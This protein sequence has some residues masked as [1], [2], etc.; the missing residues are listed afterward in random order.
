MKYI[1]FQS[2]SMQFPDIVV[3]S[4]TTQHNEMAGM[5][6]LENKEVLGAGFVDIGK[7]DYKAICNCYGKSISLNKHSRKED[8]EL[9]R[10]MVYGD[11]WDCIC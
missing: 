10:K 3:F 1:V 9:L 7:C 5:L 8:T 2:S 11:S 4:E 6:R